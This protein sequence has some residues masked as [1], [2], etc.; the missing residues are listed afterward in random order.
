[1]WG[2]AGDT[3][4]GFDRRY[5]VWFR[6][7]LQTVAS[8][9]WVTVR[10]VMWRTSEQVT[11]RQKVPK[12]RRNTLDISGLQTL[13]HIP[14]IKPVSC[15]NTR[16]LMSSTPV[17]S[18]RN[19]PVVQVCLVTGTA[20]CD[21]KE[22]G[23]MLIRPDTAFTYLCMTETDIKQRFC[24]FLSVK[25]FRCW[26]GGKQY[27]KDQRMKGDPLGGGSFHCNIHYLK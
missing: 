9:K 15:T 19:T 25:G 18:Q 12:L 13:Q 4:W 11:G 1:M 5:C 20:A 3:A 2:F 27:L 10:Q 14:Q 7:I 8:R 24:N 16:V 6:S 26:E 23:R 17:K 22:L 21:C